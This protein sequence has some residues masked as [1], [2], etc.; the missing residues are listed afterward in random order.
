MHFE[1]LTIV[2]DGGNDLVHVVGLIGRLGD[3]F[4][5]RILHAVDG[6]GAFD[7]RSLLHIVLGNVAE[8]LTNHCDS[9]VLVLGSKMCNARLGGV[10][11][12]TAELLLI[13]NFA[14]YFLDNLRAGEEHVGRVL[15]HQ[16]EVGEGRR[17][18][19]TAG[20]GTHDAGD[21]RNDTRCK[22][23]TLEDLAK[24][25]HRSDAF[26]NAGTTRVVETDERSAY[27]HGHV[28]DLADLLGHG[29]A[30]RTTADR[31]V[32]SIEEDESPADGSRSCDN[33]IAERVRLVGAEVGATVD[34]EHVGLLERAWID[35]CLNA[36][37]CRQLALGMLSSYALLATAKTCSLAILDQFLYL[38]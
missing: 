28:H 38:L 21:L 22:N 7:A 14:Q 27:T 5:Q 20:A 36:L 30:K 4:V 8:Q 34:Q 11:R 19:R 10:N 18:D 15:D 13:D 37:A 9:F 17:I 26:L 2:N 33:T 25:C 6:I 23:I 32:L 31:K 12:C 24:A 16:H 35:Q 29:D 3:D 1:H